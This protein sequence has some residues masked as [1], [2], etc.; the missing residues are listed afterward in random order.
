MRG[1]KTMGKA[2]LAIIVTFFGGWLCAAIGNDTM[3]GF[4]ELGTIGAVAIMGGF[5]IYFN[6]KKK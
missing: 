4:V 6:E 2:I 5:I 1:V 3:G